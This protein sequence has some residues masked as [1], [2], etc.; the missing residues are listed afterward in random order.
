MFL[1]CRVGLMLIRSWNSWIQ[2]G[3]CHS[4]KLMSIYQKNTIQLAEFT[5]INKFS[6]SG[7]RGWAGLYVEGNSGKY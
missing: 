6:K 4:W 3:D 1:D 7:L 2:C 5:F